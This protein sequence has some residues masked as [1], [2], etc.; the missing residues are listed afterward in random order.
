MNL[1]V[2]NKTLDCFS[3][4]RPHVG[5]KT[6]RPQRNGAIRPGTITSLQGAL[7]EN[8]RADLVKGHKSPISVKTFRP[9]GHS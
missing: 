7:K 6:N 5:T 8:K 1:Y 4:K 9:L 3:L 2:P